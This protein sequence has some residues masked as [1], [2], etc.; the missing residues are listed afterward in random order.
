MRSGGSNAGQAAD[1]RGAWN[2]ARFERAYDQ[3]ADSVHAAAQWLLRDEQAAED[4][5]QEVFLRLWRE[6]ERFDPSRGS[7]GTYLRLQARSRALDILREGHAAGRASDRIRSLAP[8]GTPAD[9]QQIIALERKGDRAIV[10]RGMRC[11]PQAQREALLLVY[12]GGLTAE[13][14]SVR[15]QVPLGTVK[16]RIRLGLRTLRQACESSIDNVEIAA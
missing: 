12:W 15:S 1:K 8:R 6:P 2:G 16:S 14:I 13:E 11:L 4:I 9:S 10:R 3:H 7:L 5:V